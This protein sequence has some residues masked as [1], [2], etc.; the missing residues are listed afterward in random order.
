MYSFINLKSYNFLLQINNIKFLNMLV[1]NS[2]KIHEDIPKM[3]INLFE[4][5]ILHVK[6]SSVENIGKFYVQFH[7]VE[8]CQTKVDTF[9]AAKNPQVC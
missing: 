6:V 7:S 8:A 2:I 4:G 3:D 9:M 1:E 5:Q